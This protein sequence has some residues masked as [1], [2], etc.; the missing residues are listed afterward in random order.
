MVYFNFNSRFS[1]KNV[2][3]CDGVGRNLIKFKF[4]SYCDAL[5]QDRTTTVP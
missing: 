1:V 3:E 2:K 5:Y 4:V